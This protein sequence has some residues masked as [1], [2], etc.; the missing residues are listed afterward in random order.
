MVT[1]F[2][3]SRERMICVRAP[4]VSSSTSAASPAGE[5]AY[6]SAAMDAATRSAMDMGWSADRTTAMRSSRCSRSLPSSGLK[7]QISS[8]RHGWRTLTPSRS[9]MFTPSVSTFSSRLAMPSSSRLISSMYSTPRCASARRPGWKTALPVFMDSSTSTEP[10]RRSSVTPS[11]TCT[12]G[13]ALT[14]VSNSGRPFSPMGN[15]PAST[16]ST[17][18][19]SQSLRSLGSALA[20]EPTTYS[21]GGS[22]AWMPRAMMDLAVPRRPL[23]Q[24]PPMFGS[25]A[26]SSSALLIAL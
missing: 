14:A 1:S 17:S 18:A 11:G 23:M 16:R 4:S 5:L 10:S 20:M 3:Y 9:T 2:R 7:V 6:F 8:G 25:T 21:M 15:S 13:V 19:G 24:M 22:S 12:K 26:P